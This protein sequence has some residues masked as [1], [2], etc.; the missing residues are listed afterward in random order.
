MLWNFI[1]F[2]IIYFLQIFCY[3]KISS[4]IPISIIRE[5]DTCVLT[6]V[7]I[8]Y[9][10]EL[11]ETRDGSQ[12]AGRRSGPAQYSVPVHFAFQPILFPVSILMLAFETLNLLAAK[13]LV[14]FV[15]VVQYVQHVIAVDQRFC[16]VCKEPGHIWC[17]LSRY[18]F[19]RRSLSR[20]V[21]RNKSKKKKREISFTFSNAYIMTTKLD[22]LFLNKCKTHKRNLMC[23]SIFLFICIFFI[24]HAC[25]IYF[26]TAFLLY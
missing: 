20:F 13:R 18:F 5:S 14:Q 21:E 3:R 10:V 23:V 12:S 9:S 17:S 16:V 8:E 6:S 1:Y 22:S 25:W 24:I 19:P 26:I 2:W 7:I 15:N 4:N 11:V